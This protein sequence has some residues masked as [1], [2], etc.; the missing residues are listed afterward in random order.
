MSSSSAPEES[1]ASEVL[2]ASLG[3]ALSAAILYPLEGKTHERISFACVCSVPMSHS[4]IHSFIH[5]YYYYT[6]IFSAKDK[7]ASQSRCSRH[8]HARVCFLSNETTRT[9][10]ILG[11]CRNK[12]VAKCHRKGRL[13]FRLYSTE[14]TIR[15][16]IPQW[17]DSDI[18]QFSTRMC[19]GMG[20]LAH[21]SAH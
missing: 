14:G 9:Q 8:D 15:S 16:F 20:S 2:S 7:N 10:G 19:R 21:Y 13:L 18:A 11:G 1:I 12:C 5:Y 4:L 6:L 17:T 3:G